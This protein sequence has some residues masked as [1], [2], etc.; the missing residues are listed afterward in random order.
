[1]NRLGIYTHQPND[2]RNNII[3]RIQG[4]LRER[5]KVMRDFKNNLSAK[6]ILDLFTVYYNFIRVHQGIGMTPAEA[7]G[8][9]LALGQNRWLGLI[10]ASKL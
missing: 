1:M 2:Y 10:Y 3:E 6:A 4:T 7:C 9:K 8:I 5:I